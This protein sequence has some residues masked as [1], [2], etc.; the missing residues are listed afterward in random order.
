MRPA[1]RR[2]QGRRWTASLLHYTE[3]RPRD[4]GDETLRWA[5]S[6]TTAEAFQIVERPKSKSTTSARPSRPRSPAATTPASPAAC[7]RRAGRRADRDGLRRG[8]RRPHRDQ[9]RSLGPG[10]RRL[11]DERQHR[12][13]HRR[14]RQP[15][16]RHGLPRRQRCRRRAGRLH[17]LRA[18]QRIW[19]STPTAAAPRTRAASAM[20]TTPTTTGGGWWAIGNASDRFS[21]TFNGN[22]SV[23]SNLF[24]NGGRSFGAVGATSASARIPPCGRRRRQR[25]CQGPS[26][27]G[28]RESG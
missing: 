28:W 11:G 20:R 5:R 14:L 15:R 24:I 4:S 25:R 17:R 6:T 19:I 7:R 12:Q 23:V 3:E 18:G 2:A 13:L 21:T 16:H 8:R 22:G 27:P 9:H 26:R 1:L 10:W